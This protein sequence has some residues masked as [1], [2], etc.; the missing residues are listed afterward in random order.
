MSDFLKIEGRHLAKALRLICAVAERK[1]S[2]PIL[3]LARLSLTVDGLKIEATNLD[4]LA[5]VRADV[6]DG[7]GIWSTMIDPGC[8]FDIAT[9]AGSSAVIVEPYSTV[10][11]DKKKGEITQRFVRLTAG[12]AVY[13]LRISHGADDFPATTFAPRAELIEEFGNGQFVNMLRKVVSAV[14]KEEVRYY[15][16]GVFWRRSGKHQEVVAT[17]GHRLMLHRVPSTGGA[18]TAHIIHRETVDVLLKHFAGADLKIYQTGK[19]GCLEFV[20]RGAAL[21]A[22]SIDGTFPDYARV[23]PSADT[24]QHCIS[25]NKDRFVPALKQVAAIGGQ[26]SVAVKFCDLS[27]VALQLRDPDFGDVTVKVGGAWPEG[28]GEFGV[29]RRYIDEMMD[30][31]DGD[32]QMR[33]SAV[34]DPILI[35]DADQTMTRVLMPMRV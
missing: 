22:T 29:N 9:A 4:M 8:L 20:A 14:S 32:V 19:L 25:L 1:S 28:F 2:T 18:D 15:L 5:T 12:D 26:R 27:G 7:I 23:I 13:E 17:D 24:A 31:C 10:F 35:V 34:T 3:S 11:V 30:A 6:I 33:L 16:N 21:M